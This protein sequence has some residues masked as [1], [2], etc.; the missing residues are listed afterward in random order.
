M[1]HD[2][3]TTALD[4]VVRLREFSGPQYPDDICGKQC[5]ADA[6]AEIVR[7]R[8]ALVVA[9]DRIKDEDYRAECGC[10]AAWKAQGRIGL[11]PCAQDHQDIMNQ[12]DAALA[13]SA[14]A[15]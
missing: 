11:C 14:N 5:M 6:A 15:Q 12:I 3:Q 10:S 7:L 2:R 8:A 9:R 4:I 13:E 1:T